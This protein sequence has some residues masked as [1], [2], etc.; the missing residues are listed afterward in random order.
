MA[1]CVYTIAEW[2][3]VCVCVREREREREEKNRDRETETKRERWQILYTNL[4]LRRESAR[5]SVGYSAH[6]GQPTIRP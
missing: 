6:P 3:C 1:V 5:G 2:R 4:S